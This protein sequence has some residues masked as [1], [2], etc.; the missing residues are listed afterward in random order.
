MKILVVDSIIPFEH[1]PINEIGVELARRLGASGSIESEVLRIPYR[2]ADRASVQRDAEICGELRLE[3]VDRV[4]AL[5]IPSCLI[6]HAAKTLWLLS[7]PPQSHA[8]AAM[9]ALSGCREIFVGSAALAR[10]LQAQNGVA[11]R[12]LRPPIILSEPVPAA[13]GGGPAMSGA[14]SA[15]E[16][17]SWS[18]VVET[19]LS[20]LLGPRSSD[21]NIA[22]TRR[23]EAC[24]CGSGKKYKHCHGRYA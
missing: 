3:N 11:S 20:S 4:I 24:P 22:A 12:L 19:L 17:N 23:N 10:Q 5:R 18:N 7:P 15:E 9:P 16:A 21:V 13:T 2:P 1:D 6:P 8:G 14:P